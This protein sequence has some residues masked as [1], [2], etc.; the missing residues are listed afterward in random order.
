MRVRYFS[1]IRFY[2]EVYFYRKL[3]AHEFATELQPFMAKD[4]KLAKDY[5]YYCVSSAVRRGNRSE[6]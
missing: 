4:F 1:S 5:Y 2:S 3:F 6:N